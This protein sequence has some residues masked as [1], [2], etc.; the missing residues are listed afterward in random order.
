MPVITLFKA[1]KILTMDR[2]RPEATHVAV[3][4]GLILAGGG[5]DC[6]EGWGRVQIDDPLTVPPEALKDIPAAG[7]VLGGQPTGDA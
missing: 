4:D 6:A 2:N 1:K 5:P 3:R 7:K